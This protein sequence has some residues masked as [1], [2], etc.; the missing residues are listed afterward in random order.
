MSAKQLK[1]EQKIRDTRLPAEQLILDFLR[2]HKIT[3]IVDRV[4]QI[5]E[6]LKDL[7]YVV[8]ERIRL[9]AI[10]SDQIKTETKL[11]NGDINK[12]EVVS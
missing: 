3:L 1:K 6:S 5:D 4:N 12:V 2:L 11:A 10:Y 9:R 8:N 7:I